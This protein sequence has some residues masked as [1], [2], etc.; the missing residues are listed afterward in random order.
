MPRQGGAGA[1]FLL[2]AAR[3]QFTTGKVKE[4]NREKVNE[5]LKTGKVRRHSIL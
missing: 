4:K 5:K 2:I 1:F 3:E